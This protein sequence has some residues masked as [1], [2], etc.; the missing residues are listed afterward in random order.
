MTMA[1]RP[2]ENV[3]PDIAGLCEYDPAGDY[4][5]HRAYHHGE[6]CPYTVV[7]S[8]LAT[9]HDPRADATTWTIPVDMVT[10][11]GAGL[12]PPL[13]LNGG[14]GNLFAHAAAVKMLRN[15]TRNYLVELEVPMLDHVRVELHLRPATNVVRD[16]DNLV[17][18][19][20]P[21]LDG[22]QPDKLERWAG[23]I[24]GDDPRYVSWVPPIIHRAVKGQPAMMWLVLTV[25]PEE[26][27][28]AVIVE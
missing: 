27:V 10:G 12:K 14:H 1:P 23:I 3:Q 4:G 13:T 16:R 7:A 6:P 18:T 25:Y 5:T 19:L 20:K 9:G 26:A 28:D 21:C 8:I 11:K 17:A 15:R 24:P 2:A 22:M